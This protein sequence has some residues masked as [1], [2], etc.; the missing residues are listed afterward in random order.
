MPTR[1]VDYLGTGELVSLVLVTYNQQEYIEAAVIGALS[2]TYSPLEIVISDDA[3]TDNTFS[4][5][6]GLIE[7]YEGPHEI[8]IIKNEQNLG[9][10]EHISTVINNVTGELVVF[11]AGDDISMD[12]RVSEILRE[13]ISG[14]RTALYMYSDASMIDKYGEK[15]GVLRGAPFRYA[16]VLDALTDN[17]SVVT[18]CTEAIHISLFHKP[19][20]ALNR[21][22][23]LEDRALAFRAM[24]L[25]ECLYINQTLVEYRVHENN[26][27]GMN[28][29]S[30]YENWRNKKVQSLDHRV[31]L[32]Q[33]F[34]SDARRYSSRDLRGESVDASVAEAEVMLCLAMMEVSLH[35]EINKYRKSANFEGKR[36]KIFLLFFSL[37]KRGILSACPR[38]YY[39]ALVFRREISRIRF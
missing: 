8:K 6:Q 20:G 29:G 32:I 31:R 3:S 16:S 30:S 17:F 5:I 19:F 39:L 22:L 12:C 4:I 34:S 27:S 10:G 7:R 9:I 13:W 1:N 25:G 28:I 33:Q 2:Q 24:L 37:C 35:S 15:K 14:G 38:L 36:L 21:N 26:I 18:G 23:S 11:C